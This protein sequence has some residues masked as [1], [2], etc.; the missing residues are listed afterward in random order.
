MGMYMVLGILF[1]FMV[2]RE[3]GHG[4]EAAERQVDA[5]MPQET[6]LLAEGGT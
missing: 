1:L 6:D 4:P 2:A 3:V 5:H